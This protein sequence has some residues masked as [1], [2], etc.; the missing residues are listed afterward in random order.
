MVKKTNLFSNLKDQTF[1]DIY[2]VNHY[3]TIDISWSLK[4]EGFGHLTLSY[5]K[6][7]GRITTDTERMSSEL[8]EKILVLAAPKLAQFFIKMDENSI[9]E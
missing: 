3:T 9:C 5:D 6:K 7:N 1:V 2:E 4:G 8:I